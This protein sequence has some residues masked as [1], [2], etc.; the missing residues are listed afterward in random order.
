MC[1]AACR[2]QICHYVCIYR[3]ELSATGADMVMQ[4][5][6][7]TVSS[8]HPKLRRASLVTADGVNIDHIE[9][10]V[11]TSPGHRDMATRRRRTGRA[12]GSQCRASGMKR[13]WF[14]PFEPCADPR[15]EGASPDLQH[16]YR[17]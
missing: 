12:P 8:L 16:S 6:L 3:V 14:D 15:E 2:H 5:I 11:R 4:K 17:M 9:S 10:P 7:A 1:C 13:L